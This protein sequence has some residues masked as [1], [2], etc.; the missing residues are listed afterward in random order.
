MIKEMKQINDVQT[1]ANPRPIIKLKSIKGLTENWLFDTGAGLTCISLKAF[2]Q[3]CQ[4]SRPMKIHGVGKNANGADGGKLFP[5]GTYVIP[6]EFEGSKILQQVQVYANLHTDAI[7]GIDAI[8]NLGITYLSR[9]KEFVFQETLKQSRFAKADL[10]TVSVLKLPAHTSCPVRLGTSCGKRHTPMAAGLKSVSTIGNLDFPQIFAQPGL[11]IPNHQGDVTVLMQNC[12]DMDI[13]IPRDTVVGYIE[14]LQN[15]SFEEIS[16]INEVKSQAQFSRDK[17][18]PKLLP[19]AKEEEFLSQANMKVPVSEK[20]A[21]RDLLAQHHDVFSTDK[22]DLGCATNFEHTIT[23]K[24]ENPTYRK[25]FPIPEAHRTHLEVE[26]K[27][28]LAMGLIQPSRSRYNSPLFLVP[29]KDGSLRVVQDFRELNANSLD[30]R[31]SMKDINE[32]IGDIG[33]A[34]ST[35][36]T[37]LDLTSG[38]WQMPLDEQSRHLTAFTVPGLGQFEWI[39]SPMGLLGCPASFQRLVEL[40]MA[41]LVNVIV[42]I[43]DILLHSKNH[44][45]HRQQL[46]KLFNRL[47]NTNL[48]VNLKKCEFGADNVSYLGYRLTPNG[49]LPGADKLKAVRDAEPPKTVHQVRQFMG[50][51]NFF[52]AHVKNFAMTAS[53]LH[54]LTSKE[55]KW[56]NGQPL[57][58]DCLKAFNSLKEAL[59]SEPLVAYPRQNRPYSL[60]VDACTGNSENNGGMGAILCQTDALGRPQ[61]IAYASKQLAKHEK[62]YTPFLVEMAAMIWGMEHFDT[63]LRGRH[64]TVFTDHK[65]LETSGKKHERTLNRIKEAFM[66][67]DFDIKYKKGSEMPADFLSRN[68]VE[69]ILISDEDLATL[70]DKDHYCSGIKNI[71]NKKS[72]ALLKPSK[73]ESNLASSKTG[74]GKTKSSEPASP[75]WKGPIQAEAAENCFIENNILWKRL[76]RNGTQTTVIVV[77][78]AIVKQLMAEVHGNIMY[79]HEGQYKTKERLIQ[80]YWWPGMDNSINRH[81][82]ECEKCQKTKKEKRPTT[83]FVSPLPQCTMPNQRIHMDLFGP[84]KTSGSGKKYIMCV[85]DAFSKYVELVALPNKEAET[86][87]ASLFS[88]W[89]CRHGLPNEIVSDNGKEFCNSVVDKMLLLM[90]VKKT[91]TSPY[92]PQTNAQVEVCNKTIATYLKTQVSTDTLD[93]ELYMAPMA[94]AYNTSFHRTLKATPFKITYGQEARTINFNQRKQYGEDSGTELFQRMQISHESMRQ[95]AREQTNSAINRNVK[96]HDKTAHP[97]TFKVGDTVLIEVKDYLNKNK[98]LAECFKGPF[99]VTRVS[100]N[101]TVTIRARTGKREYNY[102]TDML[103]LYF[104]ATT[105]SNPGSSKTGPVESKS[106]NPAKSKPKAAAGREDGGPVTR[107]KTAAKQPFSNAEA[108]P[109]QSKIEVQNITEFVKSQIPT[110]STE[111]EISALSSRQNTAEQTRSQHLHLNQQ[112]WDSLKASVKTETTKWKNSLI[113]NEW[114]NYGPKF[115]LDK[116][117][118]PLQQPGIQQP[119]WVQT[120]RKFLDSLNFQERNLVLTGDPFVEFDPFTYVLIYSFPKQAQNYP[121]I[122]QALPHIVPPPIVVQPKKRGRPLGSKNKPKPILGQNLDASTSQ[123]RSRRLRRTIQL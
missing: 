113:E 28:W 37:T 93:W 53:P 17:P 31:Y 67:W 115:K 75:V 39:V 86:V 64:F 122:V 56:K 103:K 59:C 77:P 101:N 20:Q 11:V 87:A 10:R 18:L 43:D 74:P 114:C 94:F 96:D 19:K 27:N 4:E 47:R 14:N 29:K 2:R 5:Q 54:K 110:A 41:G 32:C 62:N 116:F 65:P 107:R 66:T 90:N 38:F 119:R 73:A 12:S 60:I 95:L 49:I 105:E 81:L 6:L 55:T 9:T 40:A 71:L 8:D 61:V 88:K 57:P 21:Y 42:Y 13:E 106:T 111:A 123:P 121:A 120:R 108:L 98:K 109:G 22:T 23:T 118:L 46:H 51:C 85:T 58:E 24:N 99:L 1:K 63:Y 52:R 79:G 112:Q 33:R 76:D 89:L 25:Q 92:H 7:L 104:S 69:S 83:N 48:K 44:A 15:E 91:N 36:F 84:L 3:I 35:I 72:T 100:P 102:N 97:R 78:S 16:E 34:G 26:V 82:R 68:V 45:E 80:S 117:G 30:D 50:L 70:Q